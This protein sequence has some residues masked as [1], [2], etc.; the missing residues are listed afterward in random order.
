MHVRRP[1]PTGISQWWHQL[2]KQPPLAL[3]YTL[4]LLHACRGQQSNVCVMNC[5]RVNCNSVRQARKIT[6]STMRSAWTDPTSRCPFHPLPCTADIEAYSRFVCAYA[7]Y[8]LRRG[9]RATPAPC[10]RAMLKTRDG[11]TES[12]CVPQISA[13]KYPPDQTMDESDDKV[14]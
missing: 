13:S 2:M 7:V 5:I 8:V 4:V 14:P 11:V 6:A 10:S 1:P 9:V 12:S 3:C